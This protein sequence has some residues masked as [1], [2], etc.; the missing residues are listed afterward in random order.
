MAVVIGID[1]HK[2]SHQA[3][4]LDDRESEL[5]RLEVRA[6]KT[7][8]DRL[9]RWAAPF[10]ERTWAIESAGRLGYL[11]SQRLVAAGEHGRRR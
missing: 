2:Q 9:V 4:A 7:Q 6:T 5:S 3:V 1:P 8:V 10:P 11:L